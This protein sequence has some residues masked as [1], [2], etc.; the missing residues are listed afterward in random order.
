MN[1]IKGVV[2]LGLGGFVFTFAK[3]H[4]ISMMMTAKSILK[5]NWNVSFAYIYIV[6]PHYRRKESLTQ[7][8]D[9]ASRRSLHRNCTDPIIYNK[10]F[11]IKIA[12]IFLNL[13]KYS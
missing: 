9:E 4:F 11:H 8:Q 12:L 5:T 7:K 13:I 1:F 10:N 6:C 2:I 3:D